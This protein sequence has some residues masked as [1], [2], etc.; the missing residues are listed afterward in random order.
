MRTAFL[1]LLALLSPTVLYAHDWGAWWLVDDSGGIVRHGEVR[2]AS[3][4]EIVD[5]TVRLL[6]EHDGKLVAYFESKNPKTVSTAK[7]QLEWAPSSFLPIDGGAYVMFE[8]IASVDISRENGGET[9]VLRGF[10]VELGK[11]T[12]A[13]A[14]DRL[15]TY[16]KREQSL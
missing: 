13:A 2:R 12:K 9:Y 3:R 10:A 1:L 6:A 15:K 4:V 8:A 11:V 7:Q 16:M 5:G 14:I